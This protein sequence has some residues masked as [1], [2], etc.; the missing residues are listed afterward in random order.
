MGHRWSLPSV[1]TS[2]ANTM[3]PKAK[4]H[5]RM[6][7]QF[8]VKYGPGV[9][10][11]CHIAKEVV[12]VSLQVVHESEP[13]GMIQSQ[14]A[15]EPHCYHASRKWGLQAATDRW[16]EIAALGFG[17]PAVTLR[18][19]GIP[20]AQEQDA[21]LH[22]SLYNQ[23]KQDD[24]HYTAPDFDKCAA[25]EGQMFTV[26]L[27]GALKILNGS[28]QNDFKVGGCYYVSLCCGTDTVKLANEILT[29]VGLP[30]N[31]TQEFH[32]SLAVITPVWLPCHTKSASVLQATEEQKMNWQNA[33]GIF[34]HGDEAVNF[35]GYN[36]DATTGWTRHS[37]RMAEAG[38]KNAQIKAAM[39]NLDKDGDYE[40]RKLELQRQ[41]INIPQQI[42][43]CNTVG[44]KEK[45]TKISPPNIRSQEVL[46][47]RYGT[48]V[49]RSRNT[50]IFLRL[51]SGGLAGLILLFLARA[52]LRRRFLHL[53]AGCP[54][55]V[56]IMY[57]LMPHASSQQ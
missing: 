35:S 36:D 28:E 56:P 2:W 54:G 32:L 5:Q 21:G 23:P 12:H 27:D 37:A 49:N 30:R 41:I 46:N 52:V 50:S 34:R 13:I 4:H 1:G 10:Q 18:I 42:G 43:F 25:L 6:V 3:V 24:V 38:K 29:Q 53:G 33:L 26:T 8:V 22:I 17:G 19:P 15:F 16:S 11:N 57:G 9:G 20:F 7:T 51:L 47:E 45:L 39:D 55:P 14:D 31:D 48:V 40:S 44:C